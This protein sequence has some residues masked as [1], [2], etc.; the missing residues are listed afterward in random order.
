MSRI[1]VPLRE[2]KNQTF[3]DLQLQSL[4][5]AILQLSSNLATHT[6]KI[7]GTSGGNTADNISRANLNSLS[8]KILKDFEFGPDDYAGAF[9]TGS[10]AWNISTGVVSGKKLREQN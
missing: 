3:N 7:L 9:K 6:H 10:I 8:R 5:T 1:E 2:L 4:Q